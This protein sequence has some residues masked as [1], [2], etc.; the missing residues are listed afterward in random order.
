[1]IILKFLIDL[2]YIKMETYIFYL[3]K[4]LCGLKNMLS[5]KICNCSGQDEAFTAESVRKR[6]G[7]KNRAILNAKHCP[8][9]R[10]YEGTE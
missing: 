3:T 5:R 7:C 10:N 9:H 2:R 6:S 4:Y 1:M 8:I